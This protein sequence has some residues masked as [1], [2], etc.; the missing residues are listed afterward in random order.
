VKEIYVFGSLIRGKR[1]PGD[2]DLVMIHEELTSDQLELTVRAVEGYGT[3]LEQRMDGRLKSNRENIDIVYGA[4]LEAAMSRMRVKPFAEALTLKSMLAGL[5]DT[6][7][8]TILSLC[9]TEL[10]YSGSS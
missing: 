8:S 3:S 10:L 5:A 1:R 9:G 4:S 2:L 7:T 6:I